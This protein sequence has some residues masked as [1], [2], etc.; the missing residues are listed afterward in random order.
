MANIGINRAQ[1][2]KSFNEYA[3]EGNR[4][5]IFLS[6]ASKDKEAV[7]NI[8]GYIMKAGVDIYLDE[9]DSDLQ[10][11]IESPDNHSSVTQ[12]IEN[13][14][15]KSTDI[16]CIVSEDTKSSWWVPYE[17][18]Y[19]KKSDA[20]IATLLLE[21]VR[22]IPSYLYISKLLKDIYALNLYLDSL[23]K[24]IIFNESFQYKYTNSSGKFEPSNHHPLSKY[25]KVSRI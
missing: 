19:G 8:G 10:T 23:E 12:C 21:D 2:N 5:C 4:R 20:Q 15:S 3:S 16:L 14:L 24:S 22:E 6:H 13:G 11:A 1:M 17:V 18:G 9:N 7:R 25:V